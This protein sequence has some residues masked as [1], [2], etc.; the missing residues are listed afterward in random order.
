MVFIRTWLVEQKRFS[1]I[2]V[3]Y[4]ITNAYTKAGIQQDE[5]DHCHVNVNN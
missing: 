5:S 1:N 2:D 3:T 4:T